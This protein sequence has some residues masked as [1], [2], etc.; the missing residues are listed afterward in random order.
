MGLDST[1]AGIA[2]G[3]ANFW[4]FVYDPMWF[5]WATLR[6]L[7][8]IPLG[9]LGDSTIGQLLEEGTLECK[10]PAASGMLLGLNGA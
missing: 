1:V 6:P 2:A 9:Q 3:G 7:Q 5:S 8:E 10:N 4:G